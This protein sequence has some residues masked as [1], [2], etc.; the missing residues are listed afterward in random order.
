[1]WKKLFTPYQGD[2]F[3][4]NRAE[5]ESWDVVVLS[6]RLFFQQIQFWILS[7]LWM[8][9]LS[10]PIVTGPAAK[11]GLYQAVVAGLRD[12]AL[13]HTKPLDE[14]KR[15]FRKYFWRAMVL[16]LLK[17]FILLVILTSIWFWTTRDTWLLRSISII[18]FY[19]LVLWWLTIGFLYPVLLDQP[20]SS[21]SQ[22]IKKS[23][24]LCL[25]RPFDALLFAVVSSLLQFFGFLLLGPILLVVPAL[26]SIL[27][28][29]AYWYL[30]G[31]IIPG[32][33]DLVEYS[34]IYYDRGDDE[35]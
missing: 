4:R 7:N 28:I 24:V 20:E 3:K 8:L 15:G 18:G 16:S 33:M 6:F 30:S 34:E 9:L 32:F 31:Q 11:A 35:L 2:E 10:I 17:W 26:R 21:L 5:I 23:V 19:G 29:H 12:P 14:I 1:M 22:V 25:R 27:H 13:I